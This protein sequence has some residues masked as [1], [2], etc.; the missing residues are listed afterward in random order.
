MTIKL[1]QNREKQKERLSALF[2]F[3][4]VAQVLENDPFG[5]RDAGWPNCG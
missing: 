1:L 3:D 2:V 4:Q 5:V